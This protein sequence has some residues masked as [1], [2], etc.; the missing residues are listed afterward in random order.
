MSTQHHFDPNRAL[1]DNGRS[2]TIAAVH[3]LPSVTF[4]VMTKLIT[5]NMFTQ[6]P[7]SWTQSQLLNIGIESARASALLNDINN[8]TTDNLLTTV[9][10]QL[11]NLRLIT[12]GDPH[13]PYLLSQIPSPPPVLYVRGNVE[14]LHRTSLAVVGTRR[15]TPYGLSITT[16]LVEP[17][18]RAGITIVS[19]LA[20]GIDGQAHRLAVK[21]GSPTVAVLGCG[22]DSIYPWD[23]RQLAE[24]I[25]TAG[26][27]IISEFPIGAKPERHHFPQR[28]RI[29]SGLSKA[30]LLVEAGEKSGALITAKFAVEQNRDV[31]AV[32]GNI[33]SPE[34]IGPLNWLKLGAT[35]ITSAID[36]LRV[37]D[38]SLEATQPV[39]SSYVPQSE[40][41]QKLLQQLAIGPLHVDELIEK[42]RLDNS[43][44]SATLTLLEIN[45]AI[46]HLGGL[47]Y[48][49][50]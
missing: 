13:Y 45:G 39:I 42:S 36:I 27:A 25:I 43:V 12:L 30:V 44:V 49:K 16:T 9:N 48:S 32:P 2:E 31:L 8:L 17:V 23:H 1:A 28:N 26:G 20:L 41:E 3:Q 46:H 40:D 21:H 14:A 22:V 11:A 47:V 34:S 4:G 5:N 18:V 33:T 10:L 24:D 38:V 19:G 29:I 7:R 35:P 37:F 15:P 6:E 50:V